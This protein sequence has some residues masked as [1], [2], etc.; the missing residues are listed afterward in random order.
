MRL[1]EI[2]VT[3]WGFLNSYMLL[4]YSVRALLSV[5]FCF[6]PV[7]TPQCALTHTERSSHISKQW[8]RS[9]SDQGAPSIYLCNYH[10][11]FLSACLCVSLFIAIYHAT[12]F[13]LSSP[14]VYNL[15][16]FCPYILWLYPRH[17]SLTF[18]STL[19]SIIL[20]YCYHWLVA[21]CYQTAGSAPCDCACKLSVSLCLCLS[22][23]KPVIYSSKSLC[24]CLTFSSV[25]THSFCQLG[26]L[27]NK[28][29]T[30]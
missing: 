23:K 2:W 29:G 8:G 6:W 27:Y 13:P 20:S 7:S 25:L 24:L 17:H 14:P 5:S 1:R 12:R 4:S 3:K 9:D 16:S 30:V 11:L 26:V 22:F 21:C 18:P 28:T 19:H 10:C 15:D